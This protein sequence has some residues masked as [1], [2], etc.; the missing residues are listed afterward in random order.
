MYKY[1]D[2]DDWILEEEKEIYSI[3]VKHKGFLYMPRESWMNVLP[4]HFI[5]KYKKDPYGLLLRRRAR[6]VVGGHRQQHEVDY[7]ETY[8]ATTMME[9]VRFY[10]AVAASVAAKIAKF[11]IETFFLYAKPDVAIYVEQPPGHQIIPEGAKNGAKHSDYVIQLQVA[12]YGCKQ[13][14]MLANKDVTNFFRGIGLL[15]THTDSQ[16]FISGTFPKSF[17]IVLLFVDDGLCIYITT[18]NDMRS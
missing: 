16:V 18:T 13:S 10:L 4:M 3:D 9:S 17:V 5:Y 14:P 12:L 7:F 11:D 6:L 2:V 8:A 1:D 15:P